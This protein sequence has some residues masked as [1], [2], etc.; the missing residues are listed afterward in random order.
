MDINWVG[1]SFNLSNA[2]DSNF[3]LIQNMFSA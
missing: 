2:T 3:E 1:E